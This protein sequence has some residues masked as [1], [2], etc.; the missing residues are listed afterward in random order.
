MFFQSDGAVGFESNVAALPADTPQTPETGDFQDVSSF[1]DT[2]PVLTV[3]LASNVNPPPPIPEPSTST[4]IGVGLLA[5]P[6]Y[7]RFKTRRE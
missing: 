5:A 6:F 4:L 2:N 1:L 7:R 3:L